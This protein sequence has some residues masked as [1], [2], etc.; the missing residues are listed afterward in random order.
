MVER[1]LN[2][3]E[4]SAPVAL[5]PALTATDHAGQP[6]VEPFAAAGDFELQYATNN[7]DADAERAD[8]TASRSL[9]AAVKFVEATELGLEGVG[10]P[11]E[12]PRYGRLPARAEP[13]LKN[14]TDTGYV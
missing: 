3:T 2:G 10:W 5:L 14:G 4:K 8:A 9:N 7:D 12:E 11:S 6:V 13:V 1:I